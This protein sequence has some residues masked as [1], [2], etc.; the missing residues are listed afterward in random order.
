MEQKN[1]ILRFS[2][3]LNHTSSTWSIFSGIPSLTLML[4]ILP[5]LH[6]L[7]CLPSFLFSCPPEP[8]TYMRV[9][10]PTERA[11]TPF[12][13][14]LSCV[15]SS[16]VDSSPSIPACL[17]RWRTGATPEI[18]FSGGGFCGT[19]DLGRW[20]LSCLYST[21]L[22]HIKTQLGTSSRTQSVRNSLFFLE[23]C[24]LVMN[25]SRLPSRHHQMACSLSSA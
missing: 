5:S 12:V 7:P 3:C 21:V 11:R 16:W 19:H 2:H 17:L 18:W 6:F 22:P 20:R 1:R 8:N 9:R 14:S 23:N 24:L 15:L 10:Y 25:E 4:T 13:H